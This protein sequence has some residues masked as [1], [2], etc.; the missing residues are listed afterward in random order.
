VA[1]T[2]AAFADAVLNP[3]RARY[4]GVRVNSGYRS[5]AVNRAVG[6]VEGSLHTRGL[7]LDLGGPFLADPGHLAFLRSLGLKVLVYADHVHVEAPAGGTR[8]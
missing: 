4:P 5:P 3:L 8:G 1:P 7:A 6:G 2:L